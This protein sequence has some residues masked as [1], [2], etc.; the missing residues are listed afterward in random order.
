MLGVTMAV[1]LEFDES[2]DRSDI[3]LA[4][5]LGAFLGGE[6]GYKA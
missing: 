3:S 1:Q 4:L 6:T 5:L 2:L